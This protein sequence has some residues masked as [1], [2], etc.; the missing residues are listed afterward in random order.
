MTLEQEDTPY[1]YLRSDNQ[2]IND[3]WIYV[4]L[5]LEST[6]IR[7]NVSNIYLIDDPI[8]SLRPRSIL[9]QSSKEDPAVTILIGRNCR[10]RT[11]HWNDFTYKEAYKSISNYVDLITHVIAPVIRDWSAV[12]EV[13][14][15]SEKDYSEPLHQAIARTIFN[16]FCF[17]LQ[18]GKYRAVADITCW[19]YFIGQKTLKNWFIYPWSSLK[20]W[21]DTHM[22]L[23][24]D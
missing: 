24:N 22:G 15:E 11:E 5:F 8:T 9:T 6:A 2:G 4:S 20:V 16:N 13:K 18:C 21:Y 17:S 1:H 19:Q 23:L 3:K 14:A 12:V 10:A 7:F